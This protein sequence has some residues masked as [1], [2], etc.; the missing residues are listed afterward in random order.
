MARIA[1]WRCKKND[2]EIGNASRN[3]SRKCRPYP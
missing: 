1:V 3:Q 2:V